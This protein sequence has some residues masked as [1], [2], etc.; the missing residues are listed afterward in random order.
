M[1][2]YIVSTLSQMMEAKRPKSR[3]Y[4][5]YFWFLIFTLS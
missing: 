3:L 2:S 4:I 1:N 5:I